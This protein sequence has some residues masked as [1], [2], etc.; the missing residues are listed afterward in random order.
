MV[1]SH[2]GV[3]LIMVTIQVINTDLLVRYILIGVFSRN[4]VK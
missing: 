2:D 3:V 4:V 1:L